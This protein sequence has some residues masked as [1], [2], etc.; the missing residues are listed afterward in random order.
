MMTIL[1]APV[2]LII[3]MVLVIFLVFKKVNVGVS[4]GVGAILYGILSLGIGMPFTIVEAFNLQM[5]QTVIALTLSMLLAD[6]YNSV[7]ASTKLIESFEV[8]GPRFAAFSTPAVI[9]LLPMPGGAYVSAVVVDP[10]Y[11]SMGLSRDLK[12]FINYWFRHLWITTWPL[13]QGV[14]LASG[15][16]G[17]PTSYIMML[18]M[19][20]TLAALISG[21]LIGI[22][23]INKSK[24]MVG[25]ASEKNFKKIIH[26]WP[27][28]LIA[29][30]TIGLNLNI[31]LS[32]AITVIFFILAYRPSRDRLVHA[33]K[34]SINPTLIGVIVFSF[35]FSE[36]IKESNVANYLTE[37]LKGYAELAV[38]LIPLVIVMGTG[39]EFTYISLAFPPLAPLFNPERLL[40]AFAG[41]FMG[42]MLTPAHACLVMSAEYYKTEL[43]KTYRFILP[44]TILTTALVLVYVFLT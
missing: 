32:I 14:I 25:K 5:A 8:I 44:T 31:A 13:Y 42:A 22:K 1:N 40:L 2:A 27:F 28:L 33:L 29:I 17:L 38:F 21:L 16:L 24:T 19:P 4:L 30:L 39:V 7:G 6:I 15:L 20:I 36:F 37:L 18:N 10:L 41:G 3:C 35:I 11:E 9:G 23:E 26:V 12:T 43:P 34:Y